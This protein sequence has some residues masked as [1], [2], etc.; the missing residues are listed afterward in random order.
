[1]VAGGVAYHGDAGTS[2]SARM[3]DPRTAQFDDASHLL[4]ARFGH[5]ATL[6]PDGRVLVTGG[7]FFAR[8]PADAAAAAPI[9]PEARDP[10]SGVFVPAGTMVAERS[11]HTATLLEDGRVLIVGG[12]KRSPDRSDSPAPF[13]ELYVGP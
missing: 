5:A 12:V 7:S 4:A 11:G 6:L 8:D 3:W 2:D 10:R 13:A 9:A 1:M